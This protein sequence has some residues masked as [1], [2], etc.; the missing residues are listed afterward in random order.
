MQLS[1]A[2]LNPRFSTG[3]PVTYSRARAYAPCGMVTSPASHRC[4][5]RLVHVLG[6]PA[7]WPA[8][9]MARA[10]SSWL[11]RMDWRTA[12]REVFGSLMITKVRLIGKL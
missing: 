12:R 4:I 9:R 7:R 1:S 6:S 11:I 3:C 8:C 10:I 2:G 5:S